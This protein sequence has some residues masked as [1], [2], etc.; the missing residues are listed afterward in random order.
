MLHR[1]PTLVTASF[2]VRNSNNFVPQSWLKVVVNSNLKGE[3]ET[4]EE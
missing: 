3:V 2:F 1:A 4:R